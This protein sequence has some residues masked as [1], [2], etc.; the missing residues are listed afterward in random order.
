MRRCCQAM[1]PAGRLA[2][3]GIF[4]PSG[5]SSGASSARRT[6]GTPTRVATPG[7]RIWRPAPYGGALALNAAPGHSCSGRLDVSTAP[8]SPA[9]GSARM[10][11]GPKPNSGGV[12]ARKSRRES[13]PTRA[14]SSFAPSSARSSRFYLRSQ[15]AHSVCTRSRSGRSPV[16]RLSKPSGIDPSP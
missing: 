14:R 8:T 11:C 10:L 13:S 16:R 9:A 12:S 2:D 1:G 15:Q 6:N 3:R 4:R 5:D 7:S